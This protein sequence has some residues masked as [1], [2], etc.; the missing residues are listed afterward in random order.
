MP[1]PLVEVGV[2]G[3]TV[4]TSP[5][6]LSTGSAFTL[7]VLPPPPLPLLPPVLGLAFAFALGTV[8][9][10]SRSWDVTIW[11]STDSLA[12]C[13]AGVF[14]AELAFPVSA[15]RVSSELVGGEKDGT[16]KLGVTLCC[17]E[18]RARGVE[19]KK[20]R[21]GG[22][23]LL[24]AV[25]L[26][27]DWVWLELNGESCGRDKRAFFAGCSVDSAG[28]LDKVDEDMAVGALAASERWNRCPT[29]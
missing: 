7:A 2:A 14:G 8:A 20:P 25:E 15:T 22:E 18:M 3:G 21:R 28:A 5:A 16:A 27:A 26:W 13:H 12:A 17:G 10:I 29:H 9:G 6:G 23:P 19:L 11:L 1:L 4:S 24:G